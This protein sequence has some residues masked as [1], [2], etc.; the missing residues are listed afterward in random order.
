MKSTKKIFLALLAMLAV[1]M[2]ASCSDDED[3]KDDGSVK[4][5]FVLLENKTYSVDGTDNCAVF[6]GLATEDGETVKVFLY[7][8]DL[9]SSS[10]SNAWVLGLI[11]EEDDLLISLYKGNYVNTASATVLSRTHVINSELEWTESAKPSWK[12]ISV[13]NKKYFDIIL[14]KDDIKEL[15]QVFPE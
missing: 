14:T 7:L 15:E 2:F 13:I 6:T 3:D 11:D 5:H 8:S 1:F 12:S 4:I 9:N 10:P